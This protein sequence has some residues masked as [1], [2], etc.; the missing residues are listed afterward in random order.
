MIFWM[1]ALFDLAHLLKFIGD[2]EIFYHV[3]FM[4]NLYTCRKRL[5]GISF[6][7]IYFDCYNCPI[8]TVTPQIGVSARVAV[9]L[10]TIRCYPST[11]TLSC[12]SCSLFFLSVW[13]HVVHLVNFSQ[14]V[15][16]IDLLSHAELIYYSRHSLVNISCYFLRM[17]GAT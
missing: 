15:D 4:I 10:F 5:A 13:R 3:P 11:D 17:A 1:K 9:F 14:M 7:Y 16:S 12:Y 8:S 2:N 6:S